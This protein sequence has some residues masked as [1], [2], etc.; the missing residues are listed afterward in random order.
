[1]R[2]RAAEFVEENLKTIFAYA[3][4]RVSDKDDADDLTNDIVLAIL[5]SADKIKN[6]DAFYGYVWSIASNTCKKFI[7]RKY[8]RQTS[9]IDENIPDFEDFTDDII[10]NDDVI[11]LRREI[12]LLSK[13]YRNCTVAYYYDEMS[14]SEISAKYGI[15]IDMVKYYLFKTRKILKEGISMEREFG[16]KSFRPSPFEFVTIFSG[17]FNAEYKNLFSRKLPGQILLSAYYT[18]MTIRELALEL[19]VASVYLEDEIS[20]LEKN[21]LIKPVGNGKYQTL[22]MIFTEDFINDFYKNAERLSIPAMGEI[23]SCVRSKLSEIRKINRICESLSDERILWAVLW[24]IIRLGIQKFEEAHENH[25][26]MNADKLYKDA[27]G[28]NYGVTYE[29]NDG[30]YECNSF[31]GYAGI[32]DEYYSQAA[33]F[34][35][36]PANNRYYTNYDHGELCSR[37]EKNI[38]GESCDLMIIS[39]SERD[40]LD[41]ILGEAAGKMCEQYE[42]M[43]ECGCRIMQNH[44]PKYISDR[45]EGLMFRTLL[46]L[47]VGFIG[48]CTVKSGEIGLPKFDGPAAVC[49]I[50]K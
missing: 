41:E 17:E 45:I 39:E 26:E 35:V 40:L 16:E 6:S 18:P 36:L 38:T 29:R 25:E 42:R 43:Y 33:D 14:C 13:E 47:T 23:V 28:T 3:L 49:V 11:R 34:G 37:I 7:H 12:S 31:A 15:S 9:E 20:V 48:V 32:D 1:M 22:L 30:E 4:S 2:S 44:A 24:P 27:V 10:A 19:G 46:F 21:N 5:A 50:R 8:R